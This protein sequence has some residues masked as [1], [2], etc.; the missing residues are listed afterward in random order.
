MDEIWGEG[1]KQD[2]CSSPVVNQALPI[3]NEIY[4]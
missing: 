2:M 4:H 3:E 1:N